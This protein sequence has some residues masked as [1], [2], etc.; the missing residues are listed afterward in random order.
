MSSVLARVDQEFLEIE[1]DSRNEIEKL[2]KLQQKFEQ[3]NVNAVRDE[4]VAEQKKYNK[5]QKETQ[6]DVTLIRDM[7]VTAAVLQRDQGVQS[8]LRRRGGWVHPCQR[9]RLG[10]R[11]GQHRRGGD[12]A[13]EETLHTGA[14]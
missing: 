8:H 7:L 10:L 11:T 9:G 4:K 1:T 14:E 3:I 13:Q 12:Q 5:K 2:K 6:L